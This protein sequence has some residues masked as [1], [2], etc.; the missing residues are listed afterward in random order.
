MSTIRHS[1][2]VSVEPRGARKTS[3]TKA[4]NETD[5]RKISA[6]VNQDKSKSTT[7]PELRIETSKAND[8]VQNGSSV[9]ERTQKL[10]V[11]KS[12]LNLEG[13]LLKK[14]EF[15]ISP[16]DNEDNNPISEKTVVVLE[17]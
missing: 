14:I 13:T 3:I 12:S 15:E 4:A 1:S 11:N 8:I 2:S 17:R 6:I 9:K 10:S 7:L 5:I 16:I